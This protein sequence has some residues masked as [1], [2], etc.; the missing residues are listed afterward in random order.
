[1][2][3]RLNESKNRFQLDDFPYIW[4]QARKSKNNSCVAITV[5][6]C[7]WK[8]TAIIL[9]TIN[10]TVLRSDGWSSNLKYRYTD[11]KVNRIMPA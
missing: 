8:Y 10:N 3:I 1:M 9:D 7:K 5:I 6:E 4:I 11:T 2:E